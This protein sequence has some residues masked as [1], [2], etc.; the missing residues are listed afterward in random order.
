MRRFVII[1]S[2][3][4][5]FVSLVG[6]ACLKFLHHDSSGADF[7]MKL[8]LSL[9]TVGAILC[10]LYGDLLRA[11]CDPICVEIDV[12]EE[13]NN[14][15]DRY[16]DNDGKIYNAFCHHLIV[17]NLTP[18]RPIENCRV[19]LT[20]IFIEDRGGSWE[21]KTRTPVPRL[22]EWAPSEYS[23]DVRTFAKQQVFDVGK[24][25][26]ANHGFELSIYSAQGGAFPRRYEVG[27][28]LGLVFVVTADNYNGDDEFSFQIE[29]LRSDEGGESVKPALISRIERPKWKK[30]H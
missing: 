30:N 22:M 14:V 20:K 13:S 12:P 10:A 27:Q 6:W 7:L 19:W 11:K 5:I 15:L 2:L 18:H 21:E 16:Q 3:I 8:A 26:S 29:V 4:L 1:F 24:T 17:K 25:S 9:G 28:K 23:K